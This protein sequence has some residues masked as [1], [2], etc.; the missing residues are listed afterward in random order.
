MSLRKPLLGGSFLAT[1]AVFAAVL[2][3]PTAG[4]AAAPKGATAPANISFDAAQVDHLPTAT[5]IK[6]LVVIYQE[7]DSFDH[8]FAT[9][10]HAS[11]PAGEPAFHPA[12]GTPQ[13]NNLVTA[14]GGAFPP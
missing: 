2:S 8:Y 1:A 11:N 5:P 9:Y 10:P 12:A 4:T 6:H 14:R 3:S 13:V 7:N